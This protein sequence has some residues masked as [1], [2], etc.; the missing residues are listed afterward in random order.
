MAAAKKKDEKKKDEKNKVEKKTSAKKAA[1]K[2]VKTTAAK[3]AAKAK[4]ASLTTADLV[5]N[6]PLNGQAIRH[7][8]LTP[9]KATTSAPGDWI[10]VETGTTTDISSLDVEFAENP[11][12]I[13]RQFERAVLIVTMKQNPAS[14]GT[15]RFA[16][17]GVVA[18]VADSDPDN[19]VV[20]ELVDNGLTLIA[21]IHAAEPT[22]EDIGF[23]FVASFSNNTT[24]AVAIYESK[25][26][27]IVVKR[28]S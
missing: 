4:K 5:I 13:D 9:A 1:P 22:D 23:R 21:Y 11:S 2:A 28:P 14:G 24:G 6:V 8:E 16:L 18:D 12:A 17:G 20:V 15:W 25:D 3:P 7:F 19:D 10:F 26:P 27:T